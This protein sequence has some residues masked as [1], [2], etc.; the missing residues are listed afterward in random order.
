MI[1]IILPA[2]NVCMYIREC[3]QSVVEQKTVDNELEVIVIDDGSN[4]GTWNIIREFDVY[5]FVSIYRTGHHGLGAARNFGLSRAK[6]EY[7]LFLD[8]DDRLIEGSIDRLEI[9]ISDVASELFIFKW[10]TIS[11]TGTIISTSYGDDT[12]KGMNIACWNKCYRR[13]MIKEIKFPEDV[14]FEDAEF[15]LLARLRARNITFINS[16]LYQHRHNDAGISRRKHT[17]EKR[18]DILVGFNQVLMESKGVNEEIKSIILTNIIR[19]LKRSVM[20]NEKIERNQILRLGNFL[21]NHRLYGTALRLNGNFEFIG[22]V[23]S[24][25]LK[26]RLLTLL[27]TLLKVYFSVA[28]KWIELRVSGKNGNRNA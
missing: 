4:D 12:M 6:G 14:Y 20:W 19:Q 21:S 17:F 2:Y 3:L 27:I 23:F 10:E 9:S 18:M 16:V 8:G 7:I 24:I 11:T 28:N 5:P 15:A 13:E 1:S 22:I 26:F 25:M